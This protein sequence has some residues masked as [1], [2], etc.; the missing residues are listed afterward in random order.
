[1]LT[2][3]DEPGLSSEW[4]QPFSPASPYYSAIKLGTQKSLLAL[5]DDQDE[6]SVEYGASTHLLHAEV[7]RIYGNWGKLSLQA[8]IANGRL[9]RNIGSASFPDYSYQRRELALGFQVDTMDSLYLP[10]DGDLLA[11]SVVSAMPAWGSDKSYRQFNFDVLHAKA[12]NRHSAFLG[13]RYHNAFSG[14]VG[15]ESFYDLGGIGRFA[16][17]LPGQ[18]FA[19]NYALAYLGYNYEFGKLFGRSAVLGGSLER[20]KIWYERIAGF[21]AYQTHGSVYLGFD[22]WLGLLV[23]GYGRSNED[24]HNFFIELGRSR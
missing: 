18:Q 10:R 3:G 24:D 4:F 9:E 20:G 8:R 7:G 13:L 14:E 6:I 16:G 12:L 2:L 21:D 19:E 22:S 15:F 1:L 11:V 17:F 5:A 23:M